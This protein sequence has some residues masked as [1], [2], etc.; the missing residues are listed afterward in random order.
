M[1]KILRK[2]ISILFAILFAAILILI[3]V[4]FN[5]ENYQ[6]ELQVLRTN[7]LWEIREGGWDNFFNTGGDDEVFDLQDLEY[8]IFRKYKDGTVSV[9]SNHFPS[10]P[11][12][13][14]KKYAQSYHNKWKITDNFSKVTHIS[15]YKRKY[16]KI[17][18]LISTKTAFESV[19]P[20]IIVSLVIAVFGILI[21]VVITKKLSCWLISPVEE[22]VQSEKNFISNAS[23]ELKTPLS[24]I[25]ANIELLE[26]EI[27]ENKR[28]RYVDTETKRLISLVNQMLELVRLDAQHTKY[29][30]QSFRVDEALLNVIYPMESVAFEKKI[31]MDI[32]V[33]EEM[34]LVGNEEEIQSLM[35]ILLDN[36]I[37]YTPRDGEIVIHAGIHSH[38]FHLIVANTGEP[39]PPQQ[40]EKIFERFYRQDMA[41]ESTSNHMGLGL[42]IA[43]SIVKKH[44]GKIHAQS[45]GG[46]NTFYVTLP[47][48]KK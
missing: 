20:V 46:K 26:D 47:L 48:I 8:C 7:V 39:I 34:N 19:V 37:S 16:G 4:I 31:R 2:K 23:H 38:K 29:T 40:C 21:L 14:L 43:E 25:R 30:M 13:K 42:S 17:L 27:G 36:A 9:I 3:L 12:E 1:I 11:E 44:H 18:L 33:Q 6:H 10:I 32:D 22:S 41:R 45:A 5:W 28:L 15:K 24:V 35:S